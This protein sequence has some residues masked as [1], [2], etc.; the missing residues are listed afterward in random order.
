[1]CTSL[2][3]YMNLNKNNSNSGLSQGVTSASAVIATG[4]TRN[5]DV[6]AGIMKSQIIIGTPAR[7]DYLINCKG[8]NVN[9]V[10]LLVFDELDEILNRGFKEHVENILSHL[11]K[12]SDDDQMHD[13]GNNKNK[14][15][16]KLATKCQIAIF[17]HNTYSN[18]I[19]SFA[20][21]YMNQNNTLKIAA[22]DQT[23]TLG[24]I[25]Q[26]YI[27]VEKEDYKYGTLVDL[28]KYTNIG[29]ISVIIYCNTRRKVNWLAK[30]LKK[31]DFTGMYI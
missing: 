6:E 15:E 3:R 28:L 21:K 4:A 12:N 13:Y 17:S 22:Y 9:K 26:Y 24:G 7:V 18:Y 25:S 10:S 19:L 5:Q 14:E 2:A 29:K 20:Q 31:D 27:M 8:L 16:K 23:I 11:Q 1:M 30:Q